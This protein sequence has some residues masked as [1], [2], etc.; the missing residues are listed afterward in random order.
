M[1]LI[2]VFKEF[3][4]TG[5]KPNLFLLLGIYAHGE[6]SQRITKPICNWGRVLGV[7]NPGTL[8]N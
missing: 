8:I 6:Y 5:L 4:P 7:Y 3:Q 2:R 1:H